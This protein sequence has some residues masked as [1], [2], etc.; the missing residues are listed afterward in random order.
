LIRVEIMPSFGQSPKSFDNSTGG[1]L[2]SSRANDKA[3]LQ[4]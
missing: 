1:S 3:S 4:V 2:S